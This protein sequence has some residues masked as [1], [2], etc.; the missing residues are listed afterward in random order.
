MKNSEL[1]EKLQKL[2]SDKEVV[3]FAS[4]DIY[5]GTHKWCMGTEITIKECDHIEFNDSIYATEEDVLDAI[6]YWNDMDM[7]TEKDEI[8]NIKNSLPKRKVIRIDLDV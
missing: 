1:I 6:S 5:D 7:I 3:F 4:E 8:E 2:P